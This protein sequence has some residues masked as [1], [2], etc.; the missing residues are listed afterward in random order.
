MKRERREKRKVMGVKRE[1][2]KKVE[3]IE[4]EKREC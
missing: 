2:K 4:S 1:A 3:D